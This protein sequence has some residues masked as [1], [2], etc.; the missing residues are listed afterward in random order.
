MNSMS[1]SSAPARAAGRHDDGRGVPHDE[2][3]RRTLIPRRTDDRAV[4]L[5]ERRHGMLHEDGDLAGD[6]FVLERA[7]QLE[8]GA[9]PDVDQPLIRVSAEEALH[10]PP[11]VGTVEDRSP[12]LEVV[13]LFGRF[14]RVQERHLPIIDV[15]PAEHRVAKMNAPVVARID[16]PD[17]GGDPA[18]GDDRMGLAQERLA[19]D[20]D[21]CS[22][23]VRLD[24]GAQ[25]RAARADDQD[26]YAVTCYLDRL[27]PRGTS[28]RR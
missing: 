28:G 1:M 11:V 23:R 15:L 26:V 5:E 17:G 12:R 21:V 10:D 27:H 6:D 16:A 2:P 18:F 14:L 13:D 22:G 3:A 8:A 24:G 7:D 9:V 19:N 20:R 25:P 4:T